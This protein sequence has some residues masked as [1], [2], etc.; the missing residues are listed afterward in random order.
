M[1]FKVV[2]IPLF[3]LAISFWGCSDKSSKVNQSLNQQDTVK[4]IVLSEEKAKGI[5]E[6]P[7]HCLEVEYPNKLMQVLGSDADLKSPKQLRPIFYGCFDWHSSVHGYWSIVELMQKYPSLDA[8]GNIRAL[9]NKHIT[10][11]N[12]V[13]ELSFFNDENN[14]S[15]ERTYGWA[16]LFKLQESLSKWDDADAKRWKSNLQPLVDVLVQRYIDYLPKLVYPIRAGQHDNSAFG[17]SLS[18]DYARSVGDKAFEN[19]IIE[20]GKRLF[21][22]DVNCDLAYEPSG[23]DFLSPCL[24]EAYFMSKVLDGDIYRNWLKKFMPN[25]FAKDF[26]LKPAIVK[27]RSD[28]KLVHL[29]GLNYSRAACLY[30][31]SQKVVELSHLKVIANDHVNFSLPNLSAKDDYMGSHWLGTFALYALAKAN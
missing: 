25:L 28:G 14:T 30:G 10:A 23:Y 17:L 21:Q 9:L 26:E 11:E 8:D 31:I 12:V 20:H 16:W 24:E 6:L 1:K 2:S 5:F 4:Q 29:D 13:V 3:Y 15:F 27:D 7:I 19:A 18:L 22:H